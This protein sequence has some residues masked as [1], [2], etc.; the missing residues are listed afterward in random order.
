MYYH[1]RVRQGLAVCVVTLLLA[2]PGCTARPNAAYFDDFYYIY[3]KLQFAAQAVNYDP[4]VVD[5]KVKVEVQAFIDKY[6]RFHYSIETFRAMEL[7]NMK[8]KGERTPVDTG[9]EV[10]S[11]SFKTWLVDGISQDPEL[12][13]EVMRYGFNP[14]FSAIRE[15]ARSDFEALKVRQ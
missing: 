9:M 14:D 3:Y 15:R 8:L 4:T 6:K 2:M 10:E 11:G 12:S 1:S 5:S 7:L 13:N